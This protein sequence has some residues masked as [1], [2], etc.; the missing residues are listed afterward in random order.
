MDK[1]IL[2]IFDDFHNSNDEIIQFL[3]MMVEIID[4]LRSIKIMVLSRSQPTF[5][6]CRATN[7]Q[8]LITEIKLNGL[9]DK[10]TQDFL[11]WK[12]SSIKVWAKI[13]SKTVTGIYS[14]YSAV[15]KKM[16]AF[17]F[18]ST[19]LMEIA[20]NCASAADYL[21]ISAEHEFIIRK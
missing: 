18:G 9:D 4:K 16:A 14:S 11:K 3:S 8:N 13:K 12:K 17:V 10:S 21:K 7:I 2:L 15:P 1:D 19:G 5:Y 20:C 6:D